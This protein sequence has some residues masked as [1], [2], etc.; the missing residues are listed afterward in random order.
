MVAYFILDECGHKTEISVEIKTILYYCLELA[1]H[2][3]KKENIDFSQSVS[4]F[5]TEAEFYFFFKIA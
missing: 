4:I 3:L 2:K 1:S 5:S